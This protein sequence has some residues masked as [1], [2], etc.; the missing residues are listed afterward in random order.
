MKQAVL[1]TVAAIIAAGV[2]AV[3]GYVVCTD[4]LYAGVQLYA[5]IPA[6]I[7]LV[8]LF[9]FIDDIIHEGAHLLVGLI[10]RMGAK[11]PKI[12]IFK[13]SSIEV[14]PYGSRRMKA[15]MTATAMAGLFADLLLI[16]L[17][18]TALVIASVPSY[19][20]VVLPY[21]VYAFLINVFPFEYDS[22]KTDG[23]IVWELITNEPTA[24]V[25]LAILKIQGLRHS[26]RALGDLDEK[27]FLDVPQLPEDDV[28][29]IILTQLRYEYY[30]AVG[31]GAEADKYYRRFKDLEGYLPEE[32]R[33]GDA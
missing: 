21:A 17:G 4:G 1:T 7:V 12:R 9:S 28:N 14:Y 15:R 2:A 10:C 33:H 29:F 18:V 6:Y 19:L 20:C 32:Y 30:R 5:L 27:L 25:L 26:G 3:G 11:L 23:L 24:L 16:A 31:N 22:G 13:S 8:V